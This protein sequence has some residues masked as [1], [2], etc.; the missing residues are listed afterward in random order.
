MPELM[1][2][3]VAEALALRK[4]FPQELSG[5][6][7][8]DE[9]EQANVTTNHTATTVV[10]SHTQSTLAQAQVQ[11]TGNVTTG[12]P[13]FDKQNPTHVRS[14]G[15]F[16]QAKNQ[17]SLFDVLARRLEGKPFSKDTVEAEWRVIDPEAP[18]AEPEV[19]E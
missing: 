4:A 3:K 1:I 15:N 13:T 7:T 18:D 5:L 10:S 11:T 8:S 9:M 14:L 17:M 16:L 2:A 19:V 12:S 6:Y